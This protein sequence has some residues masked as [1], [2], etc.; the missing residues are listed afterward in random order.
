MSVMLMLTQI[1]QI[2]FV[3][4]LS[5]SWPGVFVMEFPHMEKK[6]TVKM[7]EITQQQTLF[8][9]TQSDPTGLPCL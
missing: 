6:N 3:E 7:V 9:G 1:A 4:D 5:R 8:A 2:F